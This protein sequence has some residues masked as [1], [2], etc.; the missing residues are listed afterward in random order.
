[1]LKK[2]FISMLGTIAGVWIVLGLA[3]VVIS[4]VIAAVVA[5]DSAS[6]GVKDKSILYLNLDGQLIERDQPQSIIEMLSD[7]EKTTQSLT[8]ILAAVRAAAS[9]KRIKGIYINC[10]NFE[11]G[12]ASRDEIYDAIRQFKAS[13]KWVVAY[14]DSYG[15]GEYELAS[16]ADSIYLNPMGSVAVTGVV[17][18][19]PFI[20]GLLDKIGVKMQIVRV[21][22]FKSAV[23]PLFATEMSDASRLQTQQLVDTLWL[24][25]C[26]N[27]SDARRLPVA[28][29]N[30]WVDSMITVWPAEQVLAARAVTGLKYRRE[31]ED[32]L[33]GRLDIDDDDDLP[34]V[35]P[36]DYCTSAVKDDVKGKHI[37]VLIASG[38]IVDEG[39]GGI[40]G[41]NMVPEIISL[42]RDEDV[43]ALVLRINSGGGSAFASEQIW[44]ALEYFKSQGKPFYVS[45]GDAAAS[46]GYYIACGADRIYADRTTLTGSIGV[47][48]VIP[49]VSGLVTGKLGI[50]FSDVK[51]GPNAGFVNITEPL[52]PRQLEA[53][54]SGVNLIYERFTRRVADGRGL[55][56]DSVKTIAEGRVWVGARAVELGLVDE[57]GGLYETIDAIADAADIDADRIKFYPEIE[58]NF[59]AGII[60]SA[61]SGVTAD[62]ITIDAA[63]RRLLMLLDAVRNCAP[64]QARMEPI[65]IR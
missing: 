30:G 10:S 35:T 32:L 63:T 27:I 36:A 41:R 1:M 55:S 29:V 65:E 21:G 14:G 31:V 52:T 60:R 58:D 51:S 37:A 11:S 9:D 13:G 24:A 25:V 46:G 57:I 16:L 22:T 56:Q 49:D 2:F 4:A 8:D 48:G 20:T 42:A 23:E 38:D 61:G 15:Q 47:F 12:K 28:T 44:E 43:K 64:I 40:V 26:R 7:A 54:Q 18:R 53:M 3:F 39:D 33:R 19:V 17:S 5:S 59:L 45:M 6:S 62:G 34:L 50:T